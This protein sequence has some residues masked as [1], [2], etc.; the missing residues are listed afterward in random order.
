M[1]SNEKEQPLGGRRPARRRD[2]GGQVVVLYLAVILVG[3][4]LAWPLLAP[5]L[6]GLPG[7][8]AKWLGDEMGSTAAAPRSAGLDE[9]VEM[10]EA[11]LGL[12]LLHGQAL[13][14]LQQ[15]G[16]VERILIA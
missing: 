4:V 3:G 6:G 9:R 12:A 15:P 2:G 7:P 11:S 13:R 1:D 16:R 8:W 14:T 10:L 5:R